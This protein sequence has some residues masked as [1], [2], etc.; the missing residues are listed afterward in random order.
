M[1][2]FHLINLPI[3]A[4]RLFDGFRSLLPLAV[5][6]LARLSSAALHCSTDDPL[7]KTHQL[8]G[9]H[10]IAPMF[11]VADL[12]SLPKQR[13]RNSHGNSQLPS[14]CKSSNIFYGLELPLRRP[15]L[16]GL[17]SR[18]FALLDDAMLKPVDQTASGIGTTFLSE[19]LLSFST[20]KPRH[21]KRK[22]QVD[23]VI[24]GCAVTDFPVFRFSR[25]DEKEFHNEDRHE[26][27]VHYLRDARR[28]IDAHWVWSTGENAKMKSTKS[29]NEGTTDAIVEKIMSVHSVCKSTL[30]GLED[31][32]AAESERFGRP[33]VVDLDTD[34]VFVSMRDVVVESKGRHEYQSGAANMKDACFLEESGR[35]VPTI[36]RSVSDEFAR[37]LHR[38]WRQKEH[39]LA[40]SLWLGRTS[41]LS[42]DNDN[43]NDDIDSDEKDDRE[44]NIQDRDSTGANRRKRN[45]YAQNQRQE[46]MRPHANASKG[47]SIS[48]IAN[49]S[50]AGIATLNLCRRVFLCDLLFPLRRFVVRQP[51][52][53][54]AV[55]R[56]QLCLDAI[57]SAGTISSSCNDKG[58]HQHGSGA[59]ED[60]PPPP[61][62]LGRATKNGSGET[63]EKHSREAV[64]NAAAEAKT[65]RTAKRWALLRGFMRTET[66]ASIVENGDIFRLPEAAGDPKHIP[67]HLVLPTS[68]AT[69]ATY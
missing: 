4:V 53:G 56:R 14:Y 31:L 55:V 17:D 6:A 13:L 52:L 63:G 57:A 59:T 2:S 41:P 46:K 24:S 43:D 45:E 21:K 37:A 32:L 19:S 38:I 28:S 49:E 35:S 30:A 7:G 39:H 68:N 27:V 1:H 12:K 9:S 66:C 60:P 3:N 65:A 36:S 15:C 61:P 16:V 54:V 25:R 58:R 67:A 29:S 11:S 26:S 69:S 42:D 40:S 62:P 8:V 34:E 33:I 48:L 51:T 44:E 20:Y 50:R 5:N 10:I 47:S 22:E 23:A 18:I 64:A